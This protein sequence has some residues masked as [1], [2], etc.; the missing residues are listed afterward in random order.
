MGL[1]D[2]PGI[3][4]VT[5]LCPRAAWVEL[6]SLGRRRVAAGAYTYV[7]SAHGPGGIRARVG[8][9][10]SGTAR[11][12]WHIDFLRPVLRP[13][14]VWYAPVCRAQEHVWAEILSHGRGVRIP[15]PGFGASD[16]GC[17]SHLFW[18]PV[19]PSLPAFKR[20][21]RRRLRADF[22]A[23]SPAPSSTADGAIRAVTVSG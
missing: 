6:A 15:V 2:V 1:P 4:A 11:P 21:L 3:Y 17:V 18:S 23:S 16:C 7:G 12:R 22:V 13:V 19:P 20:R 8:R 5:G 9:H 14:A 10:L